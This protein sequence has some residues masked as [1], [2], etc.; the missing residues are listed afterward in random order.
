MTENKII[1]P[2]SFRNILTQ[3][4]YVE[5]GMNRYWNKYEKDIIHWIGPQLVGEKTKYELYEKNGSKY[6]STDLDEPENGYGKFRSCLRH[7]LGYSGLPEITPKTL[8]FQIWSE[9]ALRLRQTIT[10]PRARACLTSAGG[11]IPK[12][13]PGANVIDHLTGTTAS[14]VRIFKIYR[15]SDWDLNYIL[16]EW[17]PNSLIN[18]LTVLIRH[19]EHQ[20]D[21]ET[22]KKGIPRGDVFSLEEKLAGQHYQHAGVPLPLKVTNEFAEEIVSKNIFF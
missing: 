15:D 7:P 22:G 17:L 4:D 5:D 18:Y 1:L 2:D 12:S 11:I 6:F 21:K 8:G 14:G 20:E 9:S 16:D 10:N 3:P 19:E 13:G